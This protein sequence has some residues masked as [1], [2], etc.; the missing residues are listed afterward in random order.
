MF[1]IDFETYYAKDYSLSKLTTEQYVRDPRFEVIGV[2]VKRD[3]QPTVFHPADPRDWKGS[4]KKALD[5]YNLNNEVVLAHNA[6]FDMAIL[7]WHFD[8]R[9][10]FILDTL[11]MARP[12]TMLTVG[13]S[14]KAL[15]EMF[16]IGRKG[17]EVHNMI[18]VHCCDMTPAMMH[19]YGEYCKLDVDLT[20]QLYFKLKQ[21]SSPMELRII[22]IMMR[23]FTE[24]M[25]ELDTELL[26]SHLEDVRAKQAQL[27][28]DVGMDSRDVLMSNQKFAEA[29]R[30][31]GVEPPTKISP[32]TGKES[33]AFAKKDVEFMELLEHPD[34]RVQTLVAA[35][36]GLK[37]TIEETRTEQF[38][39]IASRGELPVM[40]TYYGGHTGRACLTGDTL[41]TVKR[42]CEILQIRLDELQDMDLVWDGEEFVT[43]EGLIDQGEREVITYQGVTGTPD[44]RVYTEENPD[45]EGPISLLEASLGGYT[46]ETA[47]PAQPTGVPLNTTDSD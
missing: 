35:R 38:L 6:V 12:V 7:N 46:L 27:L 36:L 14:L 39:G 1:T 15:A 33:F 37:S 16:N 20:Y 28:R 22:D 26:Q 24:P 19:A 42:A 18:G 3:N 47:E 5:Q 29:L 13:G 8:I 23:M 41:I 10:K 31:L 2:A 21:Y 11:S 4:I 34:E 9:P 25:L 43:H 45:E 44:H 40:L 30:A 32:T 17:T